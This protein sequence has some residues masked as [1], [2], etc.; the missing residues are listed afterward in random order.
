MQEFD[1]AYVR[2][3]VVNIHPVESALRYGKVYAS[4]RLPNA[5]DP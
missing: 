5:A 1:N 2:S 4:S 3:A